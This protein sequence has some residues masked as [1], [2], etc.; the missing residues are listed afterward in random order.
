M[1]EYVL[2][3]K[4]IS[5]WKRNEFFSNFLFFVETIDEASF[6]YSFESYKYP[7][8]NCH[9]LCFD[10]RRT[11]HDIEHKILMDGNFFPISE[12]F[13]LLIAEDPF[14]KTHIADNN[15]LLFHKGKNMDYYDLTKQDIKSKIKE[16]KDIAG[17]IINICEA[18]YAYFDFLCNTII[19]NIFTLS[20]SYE[21]KEVIYNLTR[22]FVTELV[23]SG[24]SQDFIH[25]NIQDFFFNTEKEVSCDED[26][27]VAFFNR[28]SE[29]TFTFRL[30][31]MINS[32]MSRVFERLN[33]FEID[34]LTEDELIML[35]SQKKKINV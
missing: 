24:Y 3:P 4:D 2:K 11:A 9:F 23:N 21:S 14:I 16:Y 1:E 22:M 17:F 32:Q 10:V 29:E 30:K 15:I 25:K 13:E 18:N 6:S 28:F 31:F 20:S 27:L 5:H 34:E 19:E 33:Y 26:T 35:K 12:E 8:L 7:A